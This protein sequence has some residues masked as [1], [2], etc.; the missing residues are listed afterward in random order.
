M[1][2]ATR[3]NLLGIHFSQMLADL[4]GLHD[5]EKSKFKALVRQ[6]TDALNVGHSCYPLQEGDLDLIDK[7]PLVTDGKMSPLVVYDRNLYLHRYYQY[8]L[9]LAAQVNLRSKG[10][11]DFFG[12]AGIL[13]DLFPKQNEVD[14]Q[15]VAAEL[16]LH[17]KL[18]II[19]GGP[20]TG[21]TSTVARIICLLFHHL[22]ADSKFALAAPTGKAAIRLQ[23]SIAATIKVLPV[24]KE[25]KDI[26]PTQAQTIHRLLGVRKNSPKFFHSSENPM[27]WDVVI[28]DEA[29]MVDLALMSKLFDALRPDAKIVLLGDKDQLA[30]VESG[31]VLAD[32]ISSLPEN[33]V[34]LKKSYRFDTAI[35]DLAEAVKENQ[36]GKAWQILKDIEID[37]LR[38]LQGN[39]DIHTLLQGYTQYMKVIER[40]DFGDIKKLFAL[41]SSFQ[42][43][44]AT[45]RGRRGSERI[46][47]EV[48]NHL[49]G[50]K[51]VVDGWY[52][53]RP[54][55]ITR[56]DYGLGLF[57]GDIGICLEDREDGRMKVWFE[58]E[59]GEIQSFSPFRL[60]QHQTAF[61]MT[62]HKS[63]GS[64]FDEVFIVLPEEDNLALSR[65]LIYTAVTRVRKKLWLLTD[66]EIFTLALARKTQ[67]HSGLVQMIKDLQSHHVFNR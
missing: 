34:I 10:S 50:T 62:I 65:E 20:G 24:E 67:R 43:L 41:F 54:V 22:G 8:E 28:V 25:V 18:A 44:C 58:R 1:M 11:A 33:T 31:S 52:A 59:N 55:I 37:N 29:S 32:L 6:L 2:N 38:V 64:E 14:L 12:S 35:K 48:E 23:Q 49:V 21:K 7:T 47:R 61:A 40:S 15:K 9:R 63:Q 66:K 45:R 13:S 3:E 46:N 30:S 17:K 42:I 36:V 39:I 19:S 16:A 51:T 60:P 53:G 27:P 4:S 56:N 26:L 5:E 57:N